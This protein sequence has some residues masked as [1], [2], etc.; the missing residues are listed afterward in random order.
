MIIF[1]TIRYKNFLSTGNLF[2]EINLNKNKITVIYGKNG[3]GKSTLLD[4]ISYCLYN[5]A[6]RNI[7]KPQLIN[8]INEKQC[9]VEL[10]FS[11][12]DREY[13]IR[14]GQKPT[15]FQIY[16]DNILINP[17]SDNRDYQSM[18]EQNILKMNEKTFRQTIILGSADFV[19]FMQLPAQH[20]RDIIEDLLDLQIFSVMNSL[21]KERLA[22][23]RDDLLELASKSELTRSLLAA[24]QQH[25]LEMKESYENSIRSYVEKVQQYKK[26]ND[27]IYEKI[28]ILSIQ[29]NNFVT[30]DTVDNNYH[31]ATK[32]KEKVD[33]KIKAAEKTILFY[34]E[35]DTCPSCKQGLSE[36][37]KHTHILELQN[38]IK[39]YKEKRG[40]LEGTIDKIKIKLERQ[41]EKEK[42][43]QAINDE[44]R[45]LTIQS[46]SNEEFIKSIQGEIKR[47]RH[48]LQNIHDSK[49][50]STSEYVRRLNDI[51]K[52]QEVLL[53]ERE[54][55]GFATTLLKDSG[56]KS[57]IIKQY[58]SVINITINYYLKLLNFN[59]DFHLNENFEETITSRGRDIFSY[60][61]FSEG[62]KMRI[63]LSILFSW[64]SIA[65]MRNS[66][67]SN[68]LVLDEIFDSSLDYDGMDEF[69]EMMRRLTV[70]TNAFI[71]SPKA[72]MLIDKFDASISFEKVKNF[73]RIKQ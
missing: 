3:T 8:S 69:V 46:N 24:A 52:E 20:R 19:P 33:A 62:E 27:E 30:N 59:I 41:K 9:V 4:A 16:Q 50:V 67:A 31:E 57:K 48:A 5:K 35:H 51:D 56:I 70:G 28:N 53:E 23:I 2:T 34:E 65:R 54:L 32:L 25:N 61:S 11:I 47:S 29:R 49:Q 39:D 38:S 44:I 42:Q 14:R 36:T 13:L 72:D 15:I 71:L 58:V 37:H 43:L 45:G 18:L 63:D 6:Y 26:S 7:N 73:S 21:V 64:R 66:S 22:S 40:W 10:E 68:L 1:K 17:L 12:G 60:E 55:L